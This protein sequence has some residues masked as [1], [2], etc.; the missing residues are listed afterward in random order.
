MSQSFS[1]RKKILFR[2]FNLCKKI[3]IIEEINKGGLEIQD[4]MKNVIKQFLMVLAIYETALLNR[5]GRK[6]ADV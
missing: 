3:K 6:V 5:M 2:N 1:D 4:R